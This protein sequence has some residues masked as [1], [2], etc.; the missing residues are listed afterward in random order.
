MAEIFIEKY[1]DGAMRV[2]NRSTN[3]VLAHTEPYDTK[4]ERNTAV[5]QLHKLTGWPIVDVEDEI[6][7]GAGA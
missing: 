6:E 4:K 3:E 5:N 1:T 2:V 7:A